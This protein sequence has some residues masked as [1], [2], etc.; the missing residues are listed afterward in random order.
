ME[1]KFHK[2]FTAFRLLAV[3]AA[4]LAYFLACVSVSAK[5][6]DMHIRLPGGEEDRMEEHARDKRN[7]E[8]FKREKENPHNRDRPDKRDG[9]HAR[10]H[11]KNKMAKN[12]RQS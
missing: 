4:I 7:E 12:E 11:V 1:M 8:A 2:Y 9:R 3:S 5:S 10:D 6:V